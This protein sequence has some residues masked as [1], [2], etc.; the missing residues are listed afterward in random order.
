MSGHTT[1]ASVEGLYQQLACERAGAARA[2][3]AQELSVE[4]LFAESAQALED[5]AAVLLHS[6]TAF[7][8]IARSLPA[9][10]AEQAGAL[11]TLAA[12]FEEAADLCRSDEHR[13]GS[14]EERP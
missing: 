7:A 4:R 11:L 14:G 8:S 10:C 2:A 12:R 5:A 13:N 1:P 6:G 9:L 3:L